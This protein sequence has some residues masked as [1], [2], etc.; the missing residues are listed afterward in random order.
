[1]TNAAGYAQEGVTF[2]SG[3]VHAEAGLRFDGFR[4]QA[5][6][7]VDPAQN[8]VQTVF[9]PQ[10]KVNLAYTPSQRLPLTL[11]FNYGRGIS[12]QDARG[13]IL[14]PQSPKV[15]TTDFFQW[16]TSYHR[17]R[18]SG[19]ADWFLIDRSNEQVYIPDDG[20]IEFKGP[21]R[22]TEWEA[23][24]SIWIGRSVVL[25]GGVTAVSNAFYRGMFPR[26]YVDSAPHVVGNAALTL[27]NWRGFNGSL[28]YRYGNHY[29]LTGEGPPSWPRDLVCWI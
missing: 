28:R 14:Y 21:T 4:F 9:V 29:R 10:P 27:G 13:I 12:S 17:G 3:R 20:S 11:Y 19:T 18:V 6:N 15:S 24:T 1:M 7:L 23:K 2:W 25:N 26:V 16:G 22:P 8:G 5:T